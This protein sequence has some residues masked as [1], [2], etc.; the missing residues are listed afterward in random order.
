[1]MKEHFLLDRDDG[2]LSASVTTHY[3]NRVIEREDAETYRDDF[4]C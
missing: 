1:M 2:L 4:K 3:K